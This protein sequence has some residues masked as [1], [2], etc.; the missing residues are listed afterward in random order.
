MARPKSQRSYRSFSPNLERSAQIIRDAKAR[1]WAASSPDGL[2][3]LA[4]GFYFRKLELEANP[5]QR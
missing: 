5:C 1:G 2:S 4:R 3:P